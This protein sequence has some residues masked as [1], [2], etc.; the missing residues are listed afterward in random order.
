[1]TQKEVKHI[2]DYDAKTGHLIRKMPT[3]TTTANHRC[4]CVNAKGYF[5]IRVLGSRPLIHRLVWLWHYGSLPRQLDHINRDR[6]D[7]RIENLR[8]AS[9]TINN[10]NRAKFRNNTSGR[11]GV[12]RDKNCKSRWVARLCNDVIGRY[13]TFEEAVTAREKAEKEAGYLNQS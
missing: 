11:T 13:D 12:I 10:R 8:E 5:H 4:L 2:F 3:R 9:Y 7:N 6:Q 1:M